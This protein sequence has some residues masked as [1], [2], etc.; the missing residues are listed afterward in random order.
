M[1]CATVCSTNAV[2]VY[3][4]LV[5]WDYVGSNFNFNTNSIFKILFVDQWCLIFVLCS[6]LWLF[7]FVHCQSGTQGYMLRIAN[8]TQH[9][10]LKNIRN[11][12]IEKYV[13]FMVIAKI[14]ILTLKNYV[15]VSLKLNEKRKGELETEKLCKQWK[16]FSPCV[17]GK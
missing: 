9:T 11:R 1:L 2:V 7:F 12:I 17:H 10:C 6:C 16:Q 15:C 3:Y 14:F 13:R 8:S 4:T 5:S